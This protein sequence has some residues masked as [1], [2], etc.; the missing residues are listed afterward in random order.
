[1]ID[2]NNYHIKVFANIVLRIDNI[3]VNIG[4]VYF[5]KLSMMH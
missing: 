2:N 1:M 5:P 4:R 3:E